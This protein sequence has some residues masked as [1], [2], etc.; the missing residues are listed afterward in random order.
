M[1]V[2]STAG[3]LTVALGLLGLA[4]FG[5]VCATYAPV[6]VFGAVAVVFGAGLWMLTRERHPER[7]AAKVMGTPEVVRGRRRT[8]IER[9]TSLFLFVWWAAM[10]APL[11]AY[12]PRDVG[13]GAA[14]ASA[15]GALQNQVLV[16]AFG[17]VGMLFL[18][19]AVK[20]VGADYRRALALWALYLCWGYTTLFWSIDSML[21]IR[22]L[23][24]FTL[25]TLGSFGFGAG[26]YGGRPD[27]GRLFLKHLMVAGLLSALVILVPLPFRLGQFNPLDPGQRLEIGGSFATFVSRPVMVAVLALIVASLAGMRRWRTRDWFYGAFLLLPVLLLKT[28]GPVLFALLALGLVYLLYGARLRERVFQVGLALLA[29][30]G[31]YVAY[32]SGFVSAMA[33]FLTRDDADLSMSLTGRVPLWH[34]VVPQIQEQ[35]LLGVGFAAF[36]TPENLAIMKQSVGFP[37]V[38]AHNGFLEEILNNG[39]VGFGLFLLFWI[40]T[41]VLVYRRARRGDPLGWVAFMLMVFY[42]L[43]NL[44][45]SLMQEYMEFPFMAVFVVLG[46]MSVGSTLNLGKGRRPVT[47]GKS[48]GPPDPAGKTA[49]RPTAYAQRPRRIAV[50]DGRQR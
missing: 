44:T 43:L 2:S 24:A 6:P 20:R 45:N 48:A 15:T 38:S 31:A 3:R 10:V 37:V 42:L 5:G 8:A 50:R 39:A 40:S 18:I 9:L 27:G 36:W 41:T 19:P 7:A 32:F 28:R 46:I 12:S 16:A 11:A 30:L 26:F 47:K 34:V 4:L 22:S 33:P 49:L 21:T 35:P 29:G 25:V 23:V 13:S 14:Q 17:A 1:P